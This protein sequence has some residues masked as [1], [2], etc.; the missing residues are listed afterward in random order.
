VAVKFSPETVADAVD[1]DK[2]KLPD[3]I[4]PPCVLHANPATDMTSTPRINLFIVE[5][6]RRG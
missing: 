5:S 3:V 2:E 4:V 6:S 1:P